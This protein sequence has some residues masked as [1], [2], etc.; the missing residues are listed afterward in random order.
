MANPIPQGY[1]TITP[2][3]R[4]RGCSDAIA[5][6][7][8]AFGAE[9]LMRMPGPDGTSIMHA[10]LRLGDSMLMVSDEHKDWGVVGPQTLGGTAVGIHLYVPDVDASFK[11][12]V[13]AGCQVTMP[14]TNMFWGDRFAKVKDPFGHEWGI[15]TRVEDVPPAELAK[16]SEAAMK[17]MQ[18]SRPPTKK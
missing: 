1:R 5:F 16:R 4:I 9:E 7:Q 3:L 10:E 2:Y 13:D 8:K 15:A 11:R 6:Y 18:A 17:E 14:P 12:A